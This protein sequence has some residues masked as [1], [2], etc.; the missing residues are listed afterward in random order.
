MR[1]MDRIR[2]WDRHLDGQTDRQDDLP[3]LTL[4][5]G[6]QKLQTDKL[7]RFCEERLG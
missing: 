6:V 3:P 5:A 4:F 2:Y 1:D 7:N